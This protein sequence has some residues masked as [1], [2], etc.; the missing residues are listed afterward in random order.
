MEISSPNRVGGG[1]A[2]LSNEFWILGRAILLKLNS[3]YPESRIRNPMSDETTPPSA[4]ENKTAIKT[5]PAAVSADLISIDK[6]IVETRGRIS[7]LGFEVDAAKTASAL[8]MGGGVFLI[9]LAA[10]ALYDLYTGKAGVWAAVGITRDALNWIAYGC[11]AAGAALIIQ[12]VARRIRRDSSREAELEKLG[13]EYA[14]LIQQ[15]NS[16]SEESKNSER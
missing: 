12:A 14:K 9:L 8:G 6:R 7:D 4:S 2:N 16:M 15:K 5:A 13:E 3:R 1:Q 10:L 11:G